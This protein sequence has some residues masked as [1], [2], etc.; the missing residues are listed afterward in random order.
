MSETLPA[1]LWRS[2]YILGLA[3]RAV[4]LCNLGCSW[5]MILNYFTDAPLLPSL[6]VSLFL[7]LLGCWSSQSCP[8]TFLF[9]LYG[10]WDHEQ[11]LLFFPL[12]LSKKILLVSI[13]CKLFI[14]VVSKTRKNLEEQHYFTCWQ[15]VC[16]C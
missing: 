13:A 9:C 7:E 14:L 1:T 4:L 6:L 10:C 2:F 8:L 3:L 12:F 15:M 11:F 5:E 16:Y